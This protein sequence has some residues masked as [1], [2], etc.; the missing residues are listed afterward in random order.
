MKLFLVCVRDLATEAMGRP[1]CVNH[2]AQA[3]RSFS[4][5]VNKPDSEIANHAKDY[6]LW[7]VGTFDDG[8]GKV[9]SALERLARATDL[10][11]G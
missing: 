11:K 5:E 4:D 6:E 3:V 2:P 8:S 7:Q 9:E 10:V 1:F